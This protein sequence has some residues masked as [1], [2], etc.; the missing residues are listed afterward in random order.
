[1]TNSAVNQSEAFFLLIQMILFTVFEIKII[2]FFSGLLK[3]AAGEQ[4]VTVKLDIC[5]NSNVFCWIFDLYGC[6]KTK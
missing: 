4:S 5:H 6:V 2:R 1:M 3:M